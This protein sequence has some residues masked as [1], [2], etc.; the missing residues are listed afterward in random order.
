[1]MSIKQGRVQYFCYK[2]KWVTRMV[3]KVWPWMSYRL[4]VCHNFGK[5]D[6]TAVLVLNILH[7]CLDICIS[8]CANTYV[9]C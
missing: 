4:H 1:M 9:I 2:H 6:D 3:Q 7:D 5:S 8:K